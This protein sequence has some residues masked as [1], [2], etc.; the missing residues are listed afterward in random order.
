MRAPALQRPSASR[1]PSLRALPAEPQFECDHWAI[2]PQTAAANRSSSI[3]L[4]VCHSSLQATADRPFA[5]TWQV[6]PVVLISRIVCDFC[7]IQH[8]WRT[9]HRWKIISKKEIA[10]RLGRL[11]ECRSER[12]R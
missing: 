3:S 6:M 11:I 12:T 5:L 2:N 8:Q 4:S 9:R 10:I 7:V 1:P